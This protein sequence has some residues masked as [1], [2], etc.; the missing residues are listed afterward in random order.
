MVKIKNMKKEEYYNWYY[1]ELCKKVDKLKP[2]YDIDKTK[3]YGVY[4]WNK[5]DEDSENIF[6]IYADKIVFYTDD[7]TIIEE[8]KPIIDDIQWFISKYYEY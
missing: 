2:Y 7:H 4:V 6:D 1:E 8:A 3:Y 5:A